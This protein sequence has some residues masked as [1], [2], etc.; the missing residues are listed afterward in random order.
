MRLEE[1][2]DDLWNIYNLLNV[3]DLVYGT[4]RRKVCKES[5][6]GL[7]KNERKTFSLLLKVKKFDYDGD[8]DTIRILGQN[9][10]ENDY[11]GLGAYQSMDI[12]APSKI[13]LIK[14]RFD[15]MHVRKLFEAIKE[16]KKGSMIAITMEE[17]ICHIW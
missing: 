16:S 12:K 6:T 11:L 7:V 9:S 1:S 17:G 15:S 3:G 10:K 2:S 8:A 14:K 4:V 13:T 5:L